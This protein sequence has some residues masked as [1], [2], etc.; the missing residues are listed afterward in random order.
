M[1]RDRFF[2]LISMVLL[3]H[4]ISYAQLDTLLFDGLKR[5]YL[6]HLP[7]SYSGN[8]AIPLIIAFHGLGGSAGGFETTTSFSAKADTENF[9]VVYPNGTGSPASW[10]CGGNWS[11]T[12]T[13]TND[14]VGYI[15]TLIDTLSRRYKID[16]T[17]VYA[18]GFSNGS[19]MAYRLAAELSNK[20][21]AIAAG[22]GPMTLRTIQPSRPVAVIHF[23]ALNDLSISYAGVTDPHAPVYFPPIDTLMAV[24]GR[25]NGCAI[26]ADTI[27]HVSGAV[28]IKWAAAGT[29]ADVVLYRSNTGGHA[30]PIGN[31][32]ETDAA[33]D[34][35]KSHPMQSTTAVPTSGTMNTI[36]NFTLKQNFP[37]P[38]NPSTSISFSVGTYS[39]ASL[40]V[41]DMLGREVAIIF[42]GEL[43]AGSYTKQWNAENFPSGVY[44]YRLSVV[45][46]AR[47]DLVPTD[48][49]NGQAG[50]YIETKKL[51]L[52]K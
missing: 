35:F 44:F 9:V 52:L 41:H 18:A 47:R 20:I 7:S 39:H 46:S 6:L 2:I 17:R 37:N 19:M 38:F 15:S 24:W 50:S 29:G 26:I 23:H 36:K 30:W 42:S 5:T 22:S 51:V 12:V 34:F 31:V 4:V 1:K 13:N 25:I 8:T 10:N 3:F 48:G 45:P 49:G 40:R 14:D 21:A 43:S 16:S 32:S 33:W 11:P 27:F 28:G